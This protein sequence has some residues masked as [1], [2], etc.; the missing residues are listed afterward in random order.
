[1]K[2]SFDFNVYPN[3]VTDIC[4]VDI[5]N[6][7]SLGNMQIIDIT[8]RIIK[9]VSLPASNRFSVDLAELTMG[10]YYLTIKNKVSN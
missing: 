10:I 2:R 7:Q 8:G 5:S 1:M 4:Y 6:N 9:E 3:P